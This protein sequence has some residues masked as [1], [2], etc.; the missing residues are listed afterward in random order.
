MS[1][2]VLKLSIS[3]YLGYETGQLYDT[4]LQAAKSSTKVIK[5]EKQC[6]LWGDLKRSGV[7]TN[8]VEY[9]LKR[10]NISE[11]AKDRTR[12]L[13][14]NSKIR[15]AF[16]EE[17]QAKRENFKFWKQCKRIIPGYRL[18]GYLNIWRNYTQRF[19]EVIDLKHSKKLS[20]LKKK[21]QKKLT[22]PD[23]YFVLSQSFQFQYYDL[24][25][26]N[27]GLFTF[28]DGSSNNLA[29][30]IGLSRN[31]TFNDPIYPIGGSNFN[32]SAK[33]TFPYSAINGVDYSALKQERDENANLIQELSNSTD[34]N[35][36][37]ERQQA[38]ERITEID[39][40]R[41]KW[42]EFY[43]IKFTG[44]WYTK[45]KGNLVLRPRFEFGF[46]G[47]YNN[48]RGIIPFERFFVGGDGMQQ[49]GRLDGREMIPLRGYPNQSLSDNDGGTIYNKFSLELRHPI[50]LKGQTKI[51]GMAFL[52][53]GESYNNFKD[54]NPFAIKR[55]AGIGIRLFMPAFGLLGIDFGHGFDPIPGDVTKSGWN[56]HFVLGQQF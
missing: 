32:I 38:S 1:Y 2:N 54:F 19:R 44:D 35:E 15:D 5:K 4:M 34:D 7:G 27:T 52:E 16:R 25:N 45:I 26:Y 53:G 28:G 50:T 22:V 41:Y 18:Q 17:H 33:L 10:L 37:I 42:L 51:F 24:N 6:K 31:D 49:F 21:W 14:M 48:D 40:E 29:Y 55:A 11:T 9:A 12:K 47:A 3:R 20:F 30:T 13:M 43:K 36:I 39:Q 46:L 23:D 56:T 8:D